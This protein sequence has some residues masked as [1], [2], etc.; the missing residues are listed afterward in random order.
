MKPPT[1]II[2]SISVAVVASCAPSSTSSSNHGVAAPVVTELSNIPV[3]KPDPLGRKNM[4]LSPY[5]PYNIIDCKGYKSGDVAGDP[6]TAKKDTSGKI[7][8]S[9]SKYFLIP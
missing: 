9:T 2:L 4:F 5:S 7:I 3:A 8:E 6:S 1:L